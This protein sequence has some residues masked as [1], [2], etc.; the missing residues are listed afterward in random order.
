MAV[1]KEHTNCAAELRAKA[2]GK[3]A[4]QTAADETLNDRDVKRLFHELQIHQVEL[5][6][7]NKVLHLTKLDLEATRDSYFNLYELAPVGYLTINKSGLIQKANLTAVT[8]LGVERD[9]LINKPIQKFIFWDDVDSYYLQSRSAVEASEDFK[10]ELRFV[11]PDDSPFWVN[12]QATLQNDDEIWL[13]FSDIGDRKQLEQ[14]LRQANDTLE[15]LVA[16]RTI[17][18]SKSVTSLAQEITDRKKLGVQLLKSEN[19]YRTLFEM[20]DEGFSLH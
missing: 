5:E 15:E 20:M 13:A 19:Q 9:A 17:E 8:M 18:L 12:L 7:Q 11:P 1:D 16:D 10:L 6:M 4:E 3:V 14:S 2:E